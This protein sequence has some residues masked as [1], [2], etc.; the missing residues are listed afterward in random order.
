MVY[1][2]AGGREFALDIM[3]FYR[4]RFSLFG[5]DTQHFDATECASILSGLAPLFESGALKPSAISARHTL[6]EAAQA[7][8]HVAAGKGGKVV[9]MLKDDAKEN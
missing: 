1:S 5:L 2:A 8:D 9:F 6:S 3:S 4:N 7:Y